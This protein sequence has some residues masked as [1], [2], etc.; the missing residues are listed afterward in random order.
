MIIRKTHH[1]WNSSCL[2]PIANLVNMHFWVLT[3]GSVSLNKPLHI[4]LEVLTLHY[5][6][7]RCN[8]TKPKNVPQVLSSLVKEPKLEHRSPIF[9]LTASSSISPCFPNCDPWAWGAKELDSHRNYLSF[10]FLHFIFHDFLFLQLYSSYI[11]HVFPK[12][13]L[14]L[15]WTLS[16]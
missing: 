2:G 16:Y 1:A 13:K 8:E 9:M 12:L 4:I 5:S 14:F 11:W 6:H 15:V 10:I 3:P 7:F